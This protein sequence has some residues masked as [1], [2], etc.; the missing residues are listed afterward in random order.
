MAA[1]GY[2]NIIIS[3]NPARRENL[4]G[5]ATIQP[6]NLLEISGGNVQEHSTA[7]GTAVPLFALENQTHDIADGANLSTAYAS[8]A[9][10]Y[11]CHAQPGDVL[12]ARVE[13]AASLTDGVTLLASAGD[14]SLQPITVDAT[15]VDTAVIA[16]AGETKTTSGEEL[17]RV[18]I[19]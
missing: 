9:T 13:T 19:V 5:T 3:G 12:Y 15:T 11:Y 1:T 8:G 14:G 7:N 17:V 6:G 10:V 2:R 4:A 18:T 16:V